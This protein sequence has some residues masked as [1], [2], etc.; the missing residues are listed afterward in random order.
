MAEHQK[1][2]PEKG[3]E[4]E[5]TTARRKKRQLLYDQQKTP[6]EGTKLLASFGAQPSLEEHAGLLK[7]THSAEQRASI[8]AQLQRSYGNAYVQRLLDSR[9]VQVKLT[10]NPPDDVYER[11]ADKVANVVTQA[12]SEIQRQ[13]VPEEEEEVQTKLASQVQRQEVPEEEEIQ[14]SAVGSQPAEVTDSLETEIDAVRGSGQSLP[15]SIRASLEPQFGHDF[16]QVSIHTDAE[17]DR[18]SRQLD[19]EAFTTGRDIF[20]REGAYKPDSQNGKWLI[21]HELTHVVQQA[22]A[23]ARTPAAAPATGT[24]TIRPVTT[25]YYNVSGNTLEEVSQQLDPEEWGRCRWNWTY[26]TRVTDGVAS[27][28]NITLALTI[29][30]PRWRGRGWTRASAEAKAEWNRMGEALR[31]HENGHADIARSW[32]PVLKER[33]LNQPEADIET[34]WNEALA[35]HEAE[36][37]TYDADTEHGRTQGVSLDT[38]IDQPTEGE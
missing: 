36:Q 5:E 32:A 38:S 19:A 7:S 13:D 10:V 14:T 12:S 24:V 11:E 29:R 25:T 17:A 30:L 16:S 27:R 18:L 31:T 2:G 37:A 6:G 35:E 23:V 33:L 1:P 15:H 22:V 21:A 20:F 4:S 3:R 8:V 9:A 26:S 34:L 28:V